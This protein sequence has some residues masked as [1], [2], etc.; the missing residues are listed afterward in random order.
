[1]YVC[2]TVGNNVQGVCAVVPWQ[3]RGVAVRVAA[4][5]AAVGSAHGEVL[6]EVRPDGVEED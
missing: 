4:A 5:A 2:M 6:G 1:M 3:R